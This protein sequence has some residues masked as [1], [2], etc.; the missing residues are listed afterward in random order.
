MIFDFNFF[1]SPDWSPLLSIWL[2]GS[3]S[4]VEGSWTWTDQSPFRYEGTMFIILNLVSL[5]LSYFPTV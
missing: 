1:C 5:L 4:P 2:G 3:D